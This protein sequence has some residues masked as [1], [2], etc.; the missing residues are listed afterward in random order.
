MGTADLNKRCLILGGGIIADYAAVS[1]RISEKVFVICA[2]GGFLHCGRLGVKADLIVGDFDSIGEIPGGIPR[3]V[4]PAEKNYTD[5]MLAVRTAAG[6]GFSSLL[7]AGMLGGRFDH[8]LAN[9][10]SLMWC[11]ET[12]IDAVLTDGETDIRAVKDASITV[13]ARENAYFSVLALSDLCGD[14]TISGGKYPLDHYNL[15]NRDPR[16]I[17]NEFTGVPVTVTVKRGIAAVIT[18]PKR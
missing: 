2:D 13:P 5:G 16:A 12:G 15:S 17:S 3:A 11:A 18:T 7:L 9:L 4:Y 6:K 8:S 10:Q 1:A 14:V